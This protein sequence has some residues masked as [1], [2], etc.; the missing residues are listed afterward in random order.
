MKTKFLLPALF[1]F[2]NLIAFAQENVIIGTKD[3]VE[4]S[5]QLTKL[6]TNAKKDFRNNRK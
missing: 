6:E 2:T 1:L 5:Y 4:I 3:N